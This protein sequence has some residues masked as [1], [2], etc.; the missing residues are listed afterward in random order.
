MLEVGNTATRR[1]P[2]LTATEV[3]TLKAAAD[4]GWLTVTP[5]T[6]Q[7]VLN[8]WQR[9]CDIKSAPFAMVRTEPQR[10]SIWVFQSRDREWTVEQQEAI[11][12]TLA[13]AS[14]CVV[15]AN[16]VCAFAKLGAESILME[17]LLQ[18]ADSNKAAALPH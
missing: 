5:Q 2:V 17:K 3:C 6:E 8:R 12:S 14:G 1:L 7:R 9:E 15:T 18:V 4:R 13:T 16:S 11:R 10:A